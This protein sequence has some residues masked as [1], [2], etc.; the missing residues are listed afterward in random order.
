MSNQATIKIPASLL[1][2][3]RREAG[4]FNRSVGGQIEHW[5][6]LGRAIERAP[7]FDYRHVTDA[8]AGPADVDAL[9]YEEQEVFFDEFA[10]SM[11]QPGPNEEAFFANRSAMGLGVG[12][13][14][15]GLTRQLPGGKYKRI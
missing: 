3:A 5:V 4:V 1:E 13:D 6:R 11:A 10:R 7:G 14:D 12:E 9:T 8:L 2:E 15:D